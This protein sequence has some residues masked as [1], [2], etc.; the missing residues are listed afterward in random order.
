[1]HTRRRQVMS[2]KVIHVALVTPPLDSSGGIGRLMSYVVATVPS[3]DYDIV[4]LDSRG[5]GRHP[6][7][8]IFSL[9][10]VL[11]SL[12]GMKAMRRVDLAHINM[13]ERGSSV[14]KIAVGGVCRLLR[15][16]FVLHLH[17]SEFQAFFDPLPTPLKALVRCTFSNA[18][19]VLVLGQ[20]WRD[21]LCDDVGLPRNRVSILLNAAPGPSGPAQLKAKVGD[22]L[23]LLF[24][25][26]L[27]IRKGVPELLT[28][29]SD[30]RLRN[31]RWVATLAGDGDV[32]LYRKEAQRLDLA[33]R[34]TFPGWVS[35]A[36]TQELLRQSDVLVLPSHAE[37]L[38]MSVIEAFAN[39]VPVVSTRVGA[40]PDV[41]ENGV[42][43]LLIEPGNSG[44]L[45]NALMTLLHDD[46]FRMTLAKNARRTW[47]RHLDMATYTTT[48]TSNWRRLARSHGAK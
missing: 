24:L 28:A 16:P 4:L 46:N 30:H 37:G 11:V 7:L 19:L 12:V 40:L 3:S 45:L 27:G 32:N 20:A 9:T 13:A 15:I 17:A 26:R 38:P 18:D 48:L 6:A 5:H 8:S 1:V 14:R 43:G 23:N 22:P 10:W 29:L 34:L 31:E 33:D 39:S 2:S 36:E 47:E 35:M 44:E 42:N 41:I 25:G 21:Y